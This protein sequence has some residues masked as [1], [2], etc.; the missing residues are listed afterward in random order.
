MWALE[1]SFLG[2]SDFSSGC[3]ADHGGWVSR[4]GSIRTACGSGGDIADLHG[5]WCSGVW[6]LP[7]SWRRSWARCEVVRNNPESAFW[8]LLLRW[9]WRL[10]GSTVL[11][12]AIVLIVQ[13][14]D[15]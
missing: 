9:R 15:L 12:L 13:A 5:H 10:A 2:W 11:L 7:S 4:A 8:W 3:L 14:G 1:H 6:L